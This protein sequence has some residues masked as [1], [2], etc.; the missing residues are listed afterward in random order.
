MA[1]THRLINVFLRRAWTGQ[2]TKRSCRHLVMV[3]GIQPAAEVC[4]RERTID[5]IAPFFDTAPLEAEALSRRCRPSDLT[6]GRRGVR[7]PVGRPIRPADAGGGSETEPQ[8]SHAV[9]PTSSD[10]P[11]RPVAGAW[12]RGIRVFSSASDAPRSRRRRRAC[13][14]AARHIRRELVTHDN[15]QG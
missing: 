13:R 5:S 14:Q 15:A 8:R 11:A 9:A 3:N 6:E 10:R 12:R 1:V 2:F 7:L 4:V